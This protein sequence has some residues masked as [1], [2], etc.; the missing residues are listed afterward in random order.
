LRRP[1]RK[2]NAHKSQDRG[3]PPHTPPG[4][5]SPLDPRSAN[6]FSHSENRFAAHGVQGT[7]FPA[8]GAGAEPPRLDLRR[9]CTVDRACV[10]AL[11]LRSDIARWRKGVRR[12]IAADPNLE[13]VAGTYR[14]RMKWLGTVSSASIAASPAPAH[15][16][17]RFCAPRPETGAGVF[18]TNAYTPRATNNDGEGLFFCL[19]SI[20]P[21]PTA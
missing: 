3:A 10:F 13:V 16:V 6:R 19:K 11:D 21:R 5:F 2:S 8:G 1:S 14:S 18:C 9:Q 20:F 15:S 7:E 17:K 4:D 12:W